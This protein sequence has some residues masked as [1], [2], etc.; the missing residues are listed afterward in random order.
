VH[1]WE[2]EY[3]CG[4]KQINMMILFVTIFI[5]CVKENHTKRQKVFAAYS[6]AEGGY[7]VTD[8]IQPAVKYD[9]ININSSNKKGMLNLQPLF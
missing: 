3:L 1:F 7:F 5:V 8:K 4:L 6:F 2:Q 9:F